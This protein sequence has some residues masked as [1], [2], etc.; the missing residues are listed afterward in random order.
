MELFA[1]IT[2]CALQRPADPGVIASTVIEYT[3]SFVLVSVSVF[4]VGKCGFSS[5]A[6][7]AY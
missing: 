5:Q 3:D 4:S 6:Y 7:I 1:K 2:P